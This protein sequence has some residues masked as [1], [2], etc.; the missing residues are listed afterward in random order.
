L[1]T[2]D[3][4]DSVDVGDDRKKSNN[5]KGN[6]RAGGQMTAVFALQAMDEKATGLLVIGCESSFLMNS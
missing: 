4:L 2:L 1:G 6:L 5:V 3:T